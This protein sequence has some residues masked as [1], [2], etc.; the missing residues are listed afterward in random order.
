MIK[1]EL[2]EIKK[3]YTPKNCSVTKIAGCYVDGEKNKKATFVKSFHSLPEE[4]I[5]KYFDIFRKALSGTVGKNALTLDITNEAEKEGGQQDFL[6]KLRDSALQDED[7][8]ND[9]YD[10]IIS[11]FEYTGNYLILIAHDIYDIPQ[12][13]KDSFMNE[14]AS[15]DIYKYI[16]TVIC[17][18]ELAEAG[19]AFYPDN[20][21]FHNRKRDWL[22][23]L[24]ILGYLFPAFN[25]RNADIHSV[26]YY[27]KSAENLNDQFAE[28]MLG[29]GEPMSA[30]L[31]V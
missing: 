29:V 26:M 8:L 22:V 21:D 17:P 23:K 12:K 15:E 18:V 1:S 7:L 25:E 5:Y 27:S 4:E 24:P 31:R 2:S 6:L 10:R 30:G 9:Y 13:T 14:D 16:F 3:L 19:L 11:S 20:N 28:M